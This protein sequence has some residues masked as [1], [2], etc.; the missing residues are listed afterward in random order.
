MK[1][2]GHVLMG[3]AR[4]IVNKSHFFQWQKDRAANAAQN[5]KKVSEGPILRRWYQKSLSY[6][7]HFMNPPKWAPG[8]DVWTASKIL[9]I[10][11]ISWT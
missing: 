7:S 4:I 5:P 11:R 3:M 2:C 9:C 8:H 1:I 10:Q 6:F